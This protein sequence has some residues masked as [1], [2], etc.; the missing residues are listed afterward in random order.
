M[1]VTHPTCPSASPIGDAWRNFLGLSPQELLPHQ[2]VLELV[3]VTP[4]DI[5]G[6]HV[7]CEI[8]QTGY[9]YSTLPRTAVFAGNSYWLKMAIESPAAQLI[10]TNAKTLKTLPDTRGKIL[11]IGDKS[12]E[13]MHLLHNAKI[14][15]LCYSQL[16]N[17]PVISPKAR[18]HETA[19]IR[20]PVF[21]DD[22]VEVGPHT[23][24]TGPT[25]IGTNSRI[26][27]LC[28]IG[29][30]G[31]FAKKIN[32]ALCQ[33]NYYGGVIIGSNSH[34]HAKANIAASPHF[35]NFTKIG[36][37]VS[38]GISSNVGH[39]CDIRDGATVAS[40]AAVC[41]RGIIG[42]NAWIG[43]GAIVRDG[44][45][46]AD[47]AQVRIGAVAIVDVPE[48]GDVSGN[49]AFAHS[50]NLKEFTRRR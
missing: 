36:D 12:A 26:E 38:I 44:C 29:S 14:H 6:D 45:T 37:E 35:M 5:V 48:G 42:Q 41:G 15:S 7:N 33:F 27:E 34:L 50:K 30:R 22:D 1:T 13:W 40:T 21:I 46:V 49:F 11:W 25:Y 19:V 20:G 31:L 8:S 17:E 9:C 10:F 23:V 3:G 16:P 24:I 2:R 18:I 47:N 32:G 43:A 4:D 28:S 39:D